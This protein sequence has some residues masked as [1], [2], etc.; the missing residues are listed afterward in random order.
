MP[1]RL[2]AGRGGH[3]CWCGTIL[4]PALSDLGAPMTTRTI[5]IAAFVIA[6]IVLII[7]LT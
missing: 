6:V 5:A 1:T 3:A 7:L 2:A 4:V